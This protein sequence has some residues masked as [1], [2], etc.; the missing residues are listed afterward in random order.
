[1]NADINY[2][3]VNV[4]TVNALCLA[5]ALCQGVALTGLSCPI[6]GLNLSV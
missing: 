4:P 1:M 2:L 5:S 6:V 3:K